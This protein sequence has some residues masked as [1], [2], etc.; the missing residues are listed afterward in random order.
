MRR[1]LTFF[2][3]ALLAALPAVGQTPAGGT[4]EEGFN[5]IVALM[6]Q[7]DGKGNVSMMKVGKMAMA[8][9]KTVGNAGTAWTRKVPSICWNMEKAVRN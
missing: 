4:R 7:Y 6:E 1:L 5:N 9:G 2:V 3:T 8:M